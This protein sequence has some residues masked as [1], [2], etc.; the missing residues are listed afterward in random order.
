MGN[1]VC[2]GPGGNTHFSHTVI[3]QDP[4]RHKSRRTC[5]DLLFE[6]W[7]SRV[8]MPLRVHRIGHGIVGGEI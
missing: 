5:R 2:V 1:T 7:G 3:T 6:S 4:N 8:G